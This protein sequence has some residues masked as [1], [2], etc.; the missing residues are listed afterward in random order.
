MRIAI[1]SIRS[2]EGSPDQLDE[3]APRRPTCRGTAPV[4]SPGGRPDHALVR[5]RG[6]HAPLQ[7]PA[8][9]A[10]NAGLATEDRPGPT[11]SPPRGRTDRRAPGRGR[12]KPHLPPSAQGL[13]KGDQSRSHG[14][15]APHQGI[16]GHVQRPLGVEDTQEIPPSGHIERPG[17]VYGLAVLGHRFGKRLSVLLLPWRTRRARS[18][19]LS[20]P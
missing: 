10:T 16:F 4:G 3:P 1:S 18:R 8:S 19:R 6:F 17:Q 9:G 12:L 14:L 5:R 15:G 20:G 13:V 2:P 11:R 7:R